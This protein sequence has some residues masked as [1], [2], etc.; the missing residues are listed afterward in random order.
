MGV[1]YRATD[2][3]LHRP[4]AIKFL[5]IVA[6]EQAKQRFH[7]EAETTSGLNHPH[8]VTMYDVGEHEGQQYI[9][10]ELVEGGTL[11]DWARSN[12]RKSWRQSVEL[13]TGIADAL[14]AAHAAGILHRDVKPSN[15][16]IDGN[17]YAKLADFGLAKLVDRDGR[18]PSKSGS[19]ERLAPG[20]CSARSRTCRRSRP[21]AS[22]STS[23][24]TCSRSASCSMSCSRDIVRSRP[25]TSSSC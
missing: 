13:L 25:G 3:K 19:E 12:R 24:A 15:V 17:G 9:V 10:S 6:D 11:D 2:T 5:S 4:V 20:S 18:D 7:Q 1:V 23:A 14:A 21:R 16:L 8:I 22:R